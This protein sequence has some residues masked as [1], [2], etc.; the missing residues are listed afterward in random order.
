MFVLSVDLLTGRYIATA[1]NDRDRAEWPPHP[2]RLF[3]ALVAAWGEGEPESAQGTRER[4]VLEW[5][6][7]LD[8]PVVLADLPERVGFRSD[9]DVFVPVN[10]ATVIGNQ[11]KSAF[12]APPKITFGTMQEALSVLPHDRKKQARRFPC[13]V[14]EHPNVRFVWDD[15]VCPAE[16]LAALSALVARVAR[17]GH[18]SS[19]VQ[20]SVGA[21]TVRTEADESARYSPDEEHGTLVL[22]WVRPGQVAALVSAHA[23]HQETES[24]VLPKRDVAYR[25]GGLSRAAPIATSVFSDELIILVRES[26]PRLPITAAAGLASQFRRALH[27]VCEE[28]LPPVISGHAADGAPSSRPHLAYLPL[29]V[30]AGPHA[31]GALIGI[32]LA[33]P[34]DRDERDQVL[35]AVQALE[36]AGDGSGAI[37]LM[38]G[39]LGELVL[40]RDQ[41]GEERRLTLRASSWTGPS[42]RWASA[43]PVALDRNPGDLQDDDPKKRAKA[44]A[45]ATA[46]VIAAVQHIGLPTPSRIDV[47]RSVVLP[48]SAKPRVFPRFPE[49]SPK[50]P[51]VLVHVRL[52]FDEPVR[53]PVIIGAGRYLG[54]G[55]C[56]PVDE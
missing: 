39:A 51:R 28:P 15:V 38:L 45:E 29:P 8:A 26:G 56:A 17:L 10:D 47:L 54:L 44:F 20:V 55:L 12:T 31:D 23:R 53:G 49:E 19:I 42:R 24:R 30:V 4:A 43:T 9:H 16:H 32:A 22:R 27:S 11:V 41:F 5:L 34:R 48:G 3:S 35:R 46:T 6:E 1:F 40:R 13:V 25:I 18:S 14:P 52:E 33:V 37:R 21:E 36:A 7:G 2:A 50:T